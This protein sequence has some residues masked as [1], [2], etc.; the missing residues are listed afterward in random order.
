MCVKAKL[1]AFDSMGVRSMATSIETSEAKIIIDPGAALA[2]RRYGLPP[3]PLEYERLNE[4]LGVIRKEL[5]DSDMVIITHYHYD[6]YLRSKDDVEFYNGKKLYVKDP[7]TMINASQRIRAFRLFKKNK[8]EG[9]VKEIIFAD[10]KIVE[11]GRVKL[12]FSQP[13]PHGEEGTPLGYV[14]MVMV[15]EDG[16]RILHTS[17]V[18]GPISNKTLDLIFEWKPNMIILCGPPT[19]FEGYKVPTASIKRGLNNMLKLLELE[20]LETII[21]DHHLLRDLNYRERISEL[22]RLSKA[23]KIRIYNA[24]EYMGQEINQLEARRRELWGKEVG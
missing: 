12:Y 10:G 19:Y 13:V 3:H 24:A 6:H 11:Y 5:V 8:I 16:Y 1:L 20:E 9:L 7:Y 17:D 15:E 23:Y 22:L 18:Q 21:I 4:V 14:I 2:P